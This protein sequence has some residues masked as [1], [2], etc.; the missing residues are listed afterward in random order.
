MTISRRTT[1]GLI[2]GSLAT[3]A[4]TPAFAATTTVNVSLWDRGST[5]MDMLGQ[6]K[7]LGMAMMGDMKAVDMPMRMMGITVDLAAV[8]AGEVTFKATNA[9]LADIHEM[10]IAPITDPH[11]PLPYDAD[12]ERVDEEAAGSLGEVSE[13]D[14]GQSGALTLTLKPGTYILYC[15]IAGH[16][17]LGMWTLITVTE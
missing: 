8:P 4:M 6:G 1:L 2:A 14:P 17:A 5:S 16:Y 12:S 9:S 11:T 15:N 3:M 10:I 13:L 7:P